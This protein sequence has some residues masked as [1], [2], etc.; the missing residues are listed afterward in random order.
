MKHE[1][2]IFFANVYIQLKKK[3]KEFLNINEPYL[4]LNP[5]GDLKYLKSAKPCCFIFRCNY[6]TLPHCIYE[7]GIRDYAKY[8]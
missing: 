5:R 4:P 1:Y 7:Y 6:I 3:Y 8:K 2:L